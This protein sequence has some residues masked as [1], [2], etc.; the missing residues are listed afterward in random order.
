M[1]ATYSSLFRV[2][3]ICRIEKATHYINPIGG[4]SLYSKEIFNDN[5]IVL[6]FIKSFKIEY[7]QFKNEFIPWLSIIDVLM[8]NSVE[9]IKKM[10]IQYELI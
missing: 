4:M 5:D 9:D 7:Q 10:L 2:L 1:L 6:N 3:D 8:F